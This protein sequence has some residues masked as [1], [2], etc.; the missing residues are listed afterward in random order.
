MFL[1]VKF[2]LKS[3]IL[4]EKKIFLKHDFEFKKFHY[5]RFAINF[6][7]ARQILNQ[8]S[9]NASDFQ[10]KFLHRVRF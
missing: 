10:L 2:F 9:Y 6:F 7:T 5:V 1:N 4:I 3:M 8:L